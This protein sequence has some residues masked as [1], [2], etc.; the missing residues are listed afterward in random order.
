MD[1]EAIQLVN[2]RVSDL[3]DYQ[4]VAGA[5]LFFDTGRA[6]LSDA[7]KQTLSKLAQDAASVQNYMIEIAGY[8]SSTGTKELNQ[9]LSD[10]RATAVTDYLRNTANVPMRRILVPAGYGATHPAA[11]NQDAE[12]RDINQRVD[13]KV[14]VNKGIE[15]GS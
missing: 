15:E 10:E 11:S 8:A 12:G 2:K 4:T 9:K 1:A 13:V 14:L 5:A 7:D 3:A 6:S